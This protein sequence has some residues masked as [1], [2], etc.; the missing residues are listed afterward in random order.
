[1]RLESDDLVGL[2]ECPVG[3]ILVPGLPLVGQVVGLIFFVVAY[4]HGAVGHRLLRVGNCGKVLVIDEDEPEGIAGDI[5]VGSNYGRNL[6]ALESNLVGG[7]YCLGVA[8][9]GRHP[10]QVVL[11]HQLAGDHGD[12]TLEGGRF[13]GVDR[14]NLGVCHRAAQDCHVQH[15]GE[16]Y[17]VEIV[18]GA[19]DESV[20]LV[21]SNTVADAS[22]L[23]RCLGMRAL[24]FGCG[25]GSSPQLC[26]INSP[27]FCTALT[28]LTYPVQRQMLP[29]IAQRT[30]SS[31]GSGLSSS[32]AAPV[33]I[34]PGVQNPHCSPWFSLNAV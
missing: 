9:K 19:L 23:R 5:R 10:R 24:I 14:K 13:R 20:I 11:G 12:N 2:G 25:H 31:D 18:S 27:A 4:E 33:S 17:V 1:M 22:D 15:V 8:R 7:K 21:P 3:E 28:M 34:I 6:L 26:R 30:S 16:H 29:L 32:R